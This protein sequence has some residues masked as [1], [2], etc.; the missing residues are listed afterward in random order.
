MK[1]SA[2]SMSP[3]RRKKGG[4]KSDPMALPAQPEYNH[5]AHAPQVGHGKTPVSPQ[6]PPRL[7]PSNI[8]PIPNPNQQRIEHL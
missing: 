5:L 7:I 8:Q 6:L 3:R 2:F 4:A 1:E